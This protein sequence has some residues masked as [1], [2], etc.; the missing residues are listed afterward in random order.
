MTFTWSDWFG[1]A[2]H[3]LKS[4]SFKPTTKR[5]NRNRVI[6]FDSHSKTTLMD[7]VY[8]YQNWACIWITCISAPCSVKL[9][10]EKGERGKTNK[11]SSVVFLWSLSKYFCSVAFVLILIRIQLSWSAIQT[12][13]W[14][15]YDLEEPS[16]PY[17]KLVEQFFF[18]SRAGKN[19]QCACLP[20]RPC[21]MFIRMCTEAGVACVHLDFSPLTL[22]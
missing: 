9:F 8:T 16:T 14:R 18:S 11:L 21:D 1:F 22:W 20:H 3:W 17:Q 7:G 12:P 4:D 5:S 6:T 19:S 2:S 10:R 13:N 15:S